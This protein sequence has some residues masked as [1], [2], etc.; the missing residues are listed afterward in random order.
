MRTIAL[1]ARNGDAVRQAIEL[2][3]IAH[4]D[5]ASEE[6]TDEFLLFAINSGL[7]KRWADRFPDPRQEAEIGMDVILAVSLSA[8]FAGIYSLRKLG[9]VLQSAHVLGA[10]DYSVAVTEAGQGISRRGTS[11]E[12]VVSGDVL[13]KLLVKMGLQALTPSCRMPHDANNACYPYQVDEVPEALFLRRN[14]TSFPFRKPDE[15]TP[16]TDKDR[17]CEDTY[18]V[19]LG[20]T[21]IQPAVIDALNDPCVP[22]QNHCQL[23]LS[24]L[25][26]CPNAIGGSRVVPEQLVKVIGRNVEGIREF[27]GGVGLAATRSSNNVEF[28]QHGSRDF[29]TPNAE[30]ERRPTLD[31]TREKPKKCPGWAVRSSAEFK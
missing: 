31:D 20:K 7:L 26:R 14:N 19:G 5:T 16:I 1:I 30:G 28:S 25:W 11:D 9:D 21:A 24:D 6:I 22:L 4:I 15:N 23:L 12:Q 10:L 18:P 3:D 29:V 27:T 13:R 8:R 17:W 2:G